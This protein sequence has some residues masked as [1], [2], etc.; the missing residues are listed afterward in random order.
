MRFKVI[1][2]IIFLLGCFLRLYPFDTNYRIMCEPDSYYNYRLT[3]NIL[4]NGHMGNIL[5]NGDSWDI[6]SYYP[7]GRIVD[8]PPLLPWVT[9]VSYR[10]LNFI[11]PSLQLLQLCFYFPAFIAPLAG[12]ISFYLFQDDDKVT[13]ILAGLLLV[14][15]PIYTVRTSAGIFDTDMFYAIFPLLTLYFLLKA[16]NSKKFMYVILASFSVVLFSLTWE[17]WTYIYYLFTISC[18]LNFVKEKRK[19][20]ILFVVIT[21]I[22]LILIHGVNSLI[23]PFGFFM[24][25][26]YYPNIYES[27][28]E[29][30][31]PY[32][33]KFICI[34]FA[35]IYLIILF[36]FLFYKRKIKIDSLLFLTL[37][38]W[39]ITGILLYVQAIRF[40]IWLA[41]SLSLIVAII[42][43]YIGK[44][45]I[46]KKKTGKH[47]I[48]L[49][50]LFLLILQCGASLNKEKAIINKDQVA[51][52]EW[53]KNNTPQNSVIISDWSYGY[54]LET[55]A[56]RPVLVDGGSQ[57]TPRIYWICKAY[58]TDNEYY[59]SNI[60][61]LLSSSGD[62]LI[63][64]L[65][66]KTGGRHVEILDEIL[67]MD[68]NNTTK[69]LE[70]YMSKKDAVSFLK[71]KCSEQP[72]ILIFTSDRDVEVGYWYFYYSNW[73]FKA[74]KSKEILY[75]YL[76]K[77]NAYKNHVVLDLNHKRALWNKKAPHSFIIVDRNIK[78]VI[79]NKDSNF[80]IIFISPDKILIIDKNF[81]NSMFVKLV[82]LKQ[83]TKYF[84]PIYRNNSTVVWQLVTNS[85][86]FCS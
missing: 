50:V 76:K 77:E 48:L 26:S 36:A 14:T 19:F 44:L 16:K 85:S 38:L 43:N 52:A 67:K 25:K 58:A 32:G 9:A 75:I 49:F 11:F 69:I 61:Q 1:I 78:K 45:F 28:V 82:I 3:D 31:K 62:S 8:Y 13:G 30:Q 37:I 23:P 46:K 27:V 20:V 63:Y 72:N 60:L 4:K 71:N 42:I 40:I 59:S 29:L 80:S 39:V 51:A 73:N 47:V 57:N 53:I 15:N 41:I 81:E 2:L 54:F 64:S 33:L 65:Q 83:P 55:F 35:S 18:F 66:N 22:L 86:Y 70:N 10:I 56:Q 21:T 79:I 17:G 84:K 6:Y 7:T 12:I 34:T 74:G 68:K 5:K 24:P